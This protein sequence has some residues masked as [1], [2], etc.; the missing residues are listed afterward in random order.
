MQYAHP[1][2]IP[3]IATLFSSIAISHTN[4][5]IAGK[6]EPFSNLAN[7]ESWT[8]YDHADHGF[9]IPDWDSA[10]DG[11]NPDIHFTFLNAGALDFF[12][13]STSSGGAFVGDLAAGGVDAIGSDIFIEDIGSFSFGE[14]YLFSATDNRFYVS[15]IFIPDSSGWSFAFA[16]LTMEDWYVFENDGFVAVELTPEILGNITETGFTF[17]PRDVPESDGKTVALDNFTFYGALVLPEVAANTAEST[18]QLGFN[19]R[20]GIAYSIQSSPDLENW[21]PVPGEQEITG[22]SPYT[23]TRPITPGPRFFRIGIDDSLTPVPDIGQ[24]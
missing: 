3:A 8:V 10:G 12:A 19:R 15:D 2:I 11:Q 6:F 21:S 9:Y 16:S 4:A 13:D 14:F 24:E 18:F 1:R 5:Q 23:M 17:H 22:T 20:P 7:A